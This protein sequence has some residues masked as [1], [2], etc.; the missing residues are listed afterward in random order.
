M[1]AS[2]SVLFL[3]AATALAQNA[4]T[5]SAVAPGCGTADTKFE[6]KTDKSQHPA[7]QP[8]PQ[9]AVIYFVEDD[10]QFQSR[11][12][13][14][15][16]I[17]VDGTWVGANHGNSYFYLAVDPGEHHLCANWQSFVGFGANHQSAAAHFTAEAGQSYYFTVKNTWL[18]EVMI[19]KIE[20][21][22]LDSDQGQLLASR[23]AFSNSH[24]K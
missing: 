6:V 17:G 9:K 13:P 4:S 10:T 11:P 2:L 12:L 20:L 19:M 14:L 5:S 23:F 15:T 1:K 22:P 21:E 18:R 24:A 3:L 7:V 16:R 8:E